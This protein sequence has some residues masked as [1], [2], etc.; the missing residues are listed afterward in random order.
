MP[1][2][3]Y[4]WIAAVAFGSVLLIAK[5]T[6]KYSL[7]NPWLFNF[8][9]NLL[10][11]LF[12]IPFALA[13]HASLPKEWFY[14][15]IAAFFNAA[16]YITYI[17]SV[18]RLDVTVFSPLF[19]F[20]SVFA[21]LI[22]VA[23]LGEHI[24]GLESVLFLLIFIAGIFVSLD[25]KFSIKSFFNPSVGLALLGMLFLALSNVFTKLTLQTNPVWDGT[26]WIDALSVLF[27]LTTIPLFIKDIPK[28]SV[29]QINPIIFMA[30]AQVIALIASN[31]AYKENVSVT[32]FIVSLP[33]SMIMAFVFSIIKPS[34]L[35]KHTLKIYL[36]RFTAVSVMIA[37]ALKL[38]G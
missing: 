7:S 13:N 21:V 12:T 17:L 18:Y 31:T 28:L 29:K 34:L 16:F 36:I 2:Y 24:G 22:S 26:L 19:N 11:F 1:F 9:L 27:L 14:L 32:S 37:S 33:M 4:A 5:L 35:E 30:F 3:L 25:E 6:S 23:F 8:F 15:S 20:R 10:T 38:N